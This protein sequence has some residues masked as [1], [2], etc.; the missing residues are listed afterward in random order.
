MLLVQAAKNAAADLFDVIARKNGAQGVHAHERMLGLVVDQPDHQ[1]LFVLFAAGN[2]QRVVLGAQRKV[3][4]RN[5]MPD[6]FDLVL[7][8]D[9]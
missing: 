7:Q 1:P 8:G 2:E 4:F 6:R 9:L 5:V 3:I